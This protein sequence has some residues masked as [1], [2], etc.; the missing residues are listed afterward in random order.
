MSGIS[1]KTRMQTHLRTRMNR[2]RTRNAQQKHLPKTL[3]GAHKTH[4]CT[5]PKKNKKNKSLRDYR[6]QVWVGGPWAVEL[7]LYKLT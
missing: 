3:E 5:K 1:S 2:K 4:K 6:L 7:K